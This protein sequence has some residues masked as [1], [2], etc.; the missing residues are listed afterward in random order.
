MM[1][2]RWK[3]AAVAI[4]VLAGLG[5][6]KQNAAATDAQLSQA[7]LQDAYLGQIINVYKA[8]GYGWPVEETAVAGDDG[9]AA[10]EIERVRA[11]ETH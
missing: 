2:G 11:S 6:C 9:A 7:S 3:A 8:L 1:P 4:V 5:A 10:R